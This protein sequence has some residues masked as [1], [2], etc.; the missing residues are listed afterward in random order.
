MNR[1]QSSKFFGF[2]RKGSVVVAI[3]VM[4]L[5]GVAASSAPGNGVAK[6]NTAGRST[7]PVTEVKID[8]FTFTPGDITVKAGTQVTWI[9]HDDIPHTVDST[10]GKFRSD[11]LDTDEKF[12]FRFTQPGEYPFYCRMHPRMTGKIIV[13]P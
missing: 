5:S 3:A 2:K 4:V 10:D 6:S 13:Q 7:A 8:N 9:N 11:A 1:I 12:Q